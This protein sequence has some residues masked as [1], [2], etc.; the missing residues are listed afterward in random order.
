[1]HVDE[2]VDLRPAVLVRRDAREV[3][4][5]KFLGRQGAGVEG[6][7]DRFDGGGFE[8]EHTIVGGGG[9][10]EQRDERNHAAVQPG[11]ERFHASHHFKA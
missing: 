7:V 6:G 8:H 9:Q 10:D 5:D 1:M 2:G 11:S 3:E 4:P